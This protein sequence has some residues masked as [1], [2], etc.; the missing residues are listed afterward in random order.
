M[1]V[2]KLYPDYGGDAENCCCVYFGYFSL[3]REKMW[4]AL[5]FYAHCLSKNINGILWNMWNIIMEYVDRF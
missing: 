2:N 4:K 1:K 3:K 5:F